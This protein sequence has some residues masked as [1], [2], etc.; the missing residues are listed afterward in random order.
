ML[1]IRTTISFIILIALSATSLYAEVAGKIA[2]KVIDKKTGETLIGATVTLVGSNKVTS[3]NAEG[4]FLLSGIEPGAY[5]IEVKYIGYQTK[6]ISGIEIKQGVTDVDIIMDEAGSKALNEVVIKSSFKQESINTLYAKQKNSVQVTDGISADVIKRSPD[7]NTG[8]VLKRISGTSVQDGKFVV[9]RGLAERYNN[10]LMNNA[11]LPSSEPD[12]KAFAFDIVPASLVDNIVIYKTATPDL[13][14]DFAGGTINTITKDIPDNQFLEATVSLGYNSK[15]TFKNNFISAQP[16]GKYDFLGFDDGSRKLPDAYSSIKSNYTSGTTSAQKIAI[17]QQFPNTF[18]YQTNQNSLPN[19]GFQLA[20]GNS[21]ITKSANRFGYNFSLNYTNGHRVSMGERF[22]YTGSDNASQEL[23]NYQYDRNT[24]SNYKS[25]GGLLNFAYTFGRNKIAL[26]NL[27]NNDFSEDFEQTNNARNYESGG[28]TPLLYK[29]FSIETTQNGIY[30][31]ILEGQHTLGKRNII[32]DW[33]GSY[34]LSYRNQPDQRIVTIFTPVN[35]P[36]YISLSSE[37]SAKP[38]DLGRV[39]SK[40]NENIY[41]AKVNLT[42]PFKWM[43]EPQRLKIGGLVIH[44]DRTFSID[45]LGY[46]DGVGFGNRAISFTNG[47]DISN[48]F[49]PQSIQ[50][51]GIDLSRLDLSSTD[52]TGKADQDAG[53]VM[54]DNKFTEKLRFVWGARIERYDQTL[55]AAGKQTREYNNTDVLP[56]GNLTYALTPKTNLRASYFRSVNRPEFRELA[57]FRYFDYQ[58]NYIIDGDPD[59]VR[60]TIDNVDLRFE[61]YPSGGEI[62][63]FSTFYKKFKNPIEQINQGNEILTYRNATNAKDLGFEAELRKK[64]NFISEGSFLRNLTFYLNA[65][66]INA[67]VLLADGRNVSTPL[68][69]QS[70]YLINSG[71]YYTPENSDFSFNVLYNRIGER[72]KFRAVTGGADV[73]EKPRDVIDFQ[74]SKQVMKKHGELKLTLA[75]LLAQPYVFYNNYN[76]T[77]GTAYKSGEDKLIQ[78]R[79]A[80]FSASLSFKY[81][82]NFSK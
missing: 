2:G 23:L 67:K 75:D 40:L 69:G 38:N 43:D 17:A 50:Q 76:S 34:G 28:T 64:L 31:S 68:Q 47:T 3:T 46:T 70:P 62:I 82:F 48:V 65:S 14:G 8:D 25:L 74:F 45:A 80:G 56:S 81:N 42:Y 4:R 49:S 39:Y 72:L 78:S 29:G 52:Y 6:L 63:S 60:S 24:F 61:Y 79:Y 36:E 35:L 77:G 27:Y 20:T 37:N 53:Y 18:G 13:P 22:G 16:N 30:T 54:L 21:V 51:N 5:T 66:Y 59:L 26:K 15:T 10:N 41:N 71:L 55:S 11:Y 12:R 73:Y 33:S 1:K 19:V 7:R 32:L 44:R 57:G 9:I 58:T